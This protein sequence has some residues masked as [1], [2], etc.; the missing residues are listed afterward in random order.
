M[1]KP[2]YRVTKKVGI[3]SKAASSYAE[4]YFYVCRKDG[5]ERKYMIFQKDDEVKDAL[6]YE[7]PCTEPNGVKV[8]V[9]VP[10]NEYYQWVTKCQVQL[11]YFDNVLFD[12]EGFNNNHTIYRTK[13]YQYSTLCK[14]TSLHITLGNVYYPLNYEKL[15]ID[16]IDIPM[17]LRFELTD[18]IHPIPN[19][20]EIEY[21]TKVKAIIIAKIKTIAD[22]LYTLYNKE[23]ASKTT[24]SEAYDY[25]DNKYPR[26]TIAKREISLKDLESYKSIE[27]IQPTLAGI[28][29]LSSIELK[30]LDGHY[31]KNWRICGKYA[32]NSSWSVFNKDHAL[33]SINYNRTDILFILGS[34]RLK[35]DIKKY[36]KHLIDNSHIYEKVL[37]LSV[38]KRNLRGYAHLMSGAGNDQ[39]VHYKH[40]LGLNTLPKN[41]W[42]ARIQ[43]YQLVENSLKPKIVTLEEIMNS[44]EYAEFVKEEERLKKLRRASAPKSSKTVRRKEST[45]VVFNRL[46]ESSRRDINWTKVRTVYP[47]H[48]LSAIRYPVVHFF[49]EEKEKAYTFMDIFSKSGVLA[50]ITSTRDYNKIKHIHNQLNYQQFMESKPF[51]RLCTA[52]LFSQVIAKYDTIIS[53][54][55]NVIPSVLFRNVEEDLR[56]LKRYVRNNKGLVDNENAVSI[57]NHAKTMNLYDK[58][59]WN[60]YKNVERFTNEY[61]FLAYF[62]N[63]EYLDDE[64]A[65]QL[66]KTIGGLVLLQKR[67]YK[68]FQNVEVIIKTKKVKEETETLVNEYA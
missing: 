40:L 35:G 10:D 62:Q 60:E 23:V 55:N 22:Q 47:I 6:L 50:T 25:I 18:G 41:E 36:I 3:G 44:D 58:E 61:G 5:I 68:R 24:Y 9:P 31:L 8:T 16:R 63:P 52:V 28:Q 49:P 13:D 19:R 27:V 45:E 12:I 42:R 17:A 38:Y 33:S 32:Y 46:V 29:I 64:E 65:K 39:L 37:F 26:I 43:D 66:R 4:Q 2:L 14:N 1:S 21:T 48:T 11:A 53:N 34:S 51:A 56:V 54:H 7:K 30:Q 59:F 15:G 20:E 57:L 67:K